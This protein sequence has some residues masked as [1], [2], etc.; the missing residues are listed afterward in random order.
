MA[1][2]SFVITLSVPDSVGEMAKYI[3]PTSNARIECVKLEKL[4]SRLA[5]GLSRGAF[6]VQTSA[7]A[8]VRASGTYT[9]AYASIANNDTVTIGGTVLTCVTGTPSGF[10]QFKKVTDGPTTAANFAAA[11]N[12]NTTLNKY[13]TA[14]ATTTGVGVV[15]IVCRVPGVIGNL[16]SLAT[17]NGTGFTVSAALM[18]SGAGGSETTQ[19]N[20]AR[21]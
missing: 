15:T 17:S 8:P 20:Y 13:L 21:G 5:S 2:S 1:N 3:A 14:S 6:D 9:L 19:I 12:G 11:I 4:F 10:T 16:V 18:T 7:N